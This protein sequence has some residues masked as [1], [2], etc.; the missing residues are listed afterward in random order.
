MHFNKRGVLHKT[1]PKADIRSWM[2][3]QASITRE[4]NSR[5]K[6]AGGVLTCQQTEVK[7]K[8]SRWPMVTFSTR[9]RPCALTLGLGTLVLS[10]G[11]AHAGQ[12][13]VTYTASQGASAPHGSAA[14]PLRQ[15]V[16]S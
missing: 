3:P 12:W 4:A 8:L 11:A 9:L 5:S 1:S 10:L 7:V 14:K 16:Q 6:N 2:R 13:K 15:S